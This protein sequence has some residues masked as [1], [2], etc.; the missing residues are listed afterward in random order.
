MHV[1]RLDV[2]SDLSTSGKICN[3]LLGIQALQIDFQ[4]I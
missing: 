3:V 2:Q 1:L 4:F